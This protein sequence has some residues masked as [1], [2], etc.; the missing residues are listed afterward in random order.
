MKIIHLCA[1]LKPW[2]RTWSDTLTSS[3]CNE[4]NGQVTLSEWTKTAP[5]KK[6]FN[7]Q[8]IGTR[9]KDMPNCRWI[10]GLEKD[11]VLRTKNWRTLAERWLACKRFLEEV[12]AHPG[13]VS[14]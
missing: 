5:V 8:P 6:V 9:R 3:K 4:L 2:F 13:L 7:T 1:L 12:N 11:L 14:D 10:D